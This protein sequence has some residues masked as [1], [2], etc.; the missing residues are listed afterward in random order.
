MKKIILFALIFFLSFSPAY[1]NPVKRLFEKATEAFNSKEYKKSA[2]L[3]TKVL[4]M[5][6]QLAPA[7]NYLGLCHKYMGSNEMVIINNF[8]KAIEI[9]PAY[10][11]AYD[12]LAK[13]YYGLGEYQKAEKYNLKALELDPTLISSQLSLGWIN[14]LGKSDAEEAI[15]YFTQ[16][17]NKS[18][19]AFAN[20]GLGLAYFLDGQHSEILSI[21]TSLR[22]S[23]ENNLASHLETMVREDRYIV[24][25]GVGM[26]F[27]LRKKKEE[28]PMPKAVKQEEKVPGA[29]MKVRLR[30]Q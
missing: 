17:V 27:A 13:I 11:L 28:V 6:P 12:N 3:F 10:T 23:G 25:S 16:V 29:G 2:D 20:F 4:S 8:K 22:K 5:Y 18:N 7:Y 30:R 21:I 9:D 1:S 15:Y 14:L 24:P 26:P 19:L